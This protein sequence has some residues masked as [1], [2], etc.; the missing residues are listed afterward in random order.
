MNTTYSVVT[1]TPDAKDLPYFGKCL[2]TNAE[3]MIFPFYFIN[4][5]YES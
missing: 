5:I 2:V 3:Y 1:Y 4:L